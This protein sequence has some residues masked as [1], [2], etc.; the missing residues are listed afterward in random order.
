MVKTIKDSLKKEEKDAATKKTKPLD[1]I[2]SAVQTVNPG[3]TIQFQGIDGNPPYKYKISSNFSG[4][5]ISSSGLYRAG[6]RTNGQDD[7]LCQ[8][9]KGNKSYTA[10][11][12]KAVTVSSPPAPP[13]GTANTVQP[14]P[15]PSVGII[16]NYSATP[17]AIITIDG[18]P[19]EVN[20]PGKSYS[21]TKLDAT[22]LRFELRTGD[23]YCTE[24]YCD[25][26][27]SERSEVTN[28]IDAYDAG[29]TWNFKYDFLVE[30]GSPVTSDW[31]VFG[32][33]HDVGPGDSPPYSVAIM[34][35]DYLAFQIGWL[36]AHSSSVES[37][38]DTEVNGMDV[39]YGWA[40]V[41]PNPLQR[42]RLYNFDISI[43]LH[44]TSGFLR[45]VRNGI[46]VVNYTGPLGFGFANKW[47]YGI[48]RNTSPETLAVVYKNMTFSNS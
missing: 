37:I 17:D 24:N 8:D 47:E 10:V 20:T 46:T 45:V 14:T 5:T 32:Q 11:K 3:K 42:N 13:P 21:M 23:K 19:Y 48:Y 36:R 27:G 15:A 33:L 16:T 9:A 35:G 1:M 41:D 2:P 7:V 28:Y 18:R 39:S 31:S 4:A 22:T 40:W 29:T 26:D 44:T 43:K 38:W 12:V 6:S 25:S 34:P 30:P